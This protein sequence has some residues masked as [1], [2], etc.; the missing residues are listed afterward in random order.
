MFPHYCQ[1]IHGRLSPKTSPLYWIVLRVKIEGMKILKLLCAFLA[2]S[3]ASSALAVTELGGNFSYSKQVYGRTRGNTL[4]SK[5]YTASVA[6]YLFKGT[7]LE[8]NYSKQEDRQE[9]TE[10]LSGGTLVIDNYENVVKTDIY[11]IGLR[12]LLGSRRSFIVPMVSLGY[13]KQFRESQQIFKIVDA[14][15]PKVLSVTNPT[16]RID[17][18]FGTFAL[19][20]NVSRLFSLNISVN[21]VFK[22]FEFNEAKDYVKYAGGFTWYF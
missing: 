2:F 16:E 14:G 8:L 10:N 5:V 7:A 20:F 11:G 18:V 6:F 13:A 1:I 21:T 12:Q 22:A 9:D 3:S 19:R 17:S 15:T 4:V